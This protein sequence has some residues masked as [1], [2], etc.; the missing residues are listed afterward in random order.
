MRA[1]PLSNAAVIERLNADFVNAWILRRDLMALA[2]QT[3]AP[4][5]FGKLVLERF[6]YPVD[7]LAFTSHGGFVG[8]IPAN[9]EGA[10][11]AQRFIELLDAA[12]RAQ[13]AG[14]TDPAK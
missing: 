7:N 5:R 11:S 1:G 6:E 4:G 2:R 12:V 14:S 10:D 9:S 3:N 13:A 8:H